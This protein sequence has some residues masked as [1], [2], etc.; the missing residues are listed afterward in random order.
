MNK[1]RLPQV[2][3]KTCASCQKT[4]TSTYPTQLVQNWK[5]HLESKKHLKRTGGVKLPELPPE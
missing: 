4:V 2:L 3:S 1:Q 5:K